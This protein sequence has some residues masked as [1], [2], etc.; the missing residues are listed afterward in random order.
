MSQ[1]LWPARTG[2][3][4]SDG[5]PRSRSTS[6]RR[7]CG[8]AVGHASA[9]A[10]ANVHAFLWRTEISA[11]V[12][13]FTPHFQYPLFCRPVFALFL[14]KKHWMTISHIWSREKV[15]LFDV[16]VF[17]RSSKF[18]R[19]SKYSSGGVAFLATVNYRSSQSWTV[20]VRL[21]F[22]LRVVMFLIT[23]V[24]LLPLTSNHR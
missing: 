11:R 24:K 8:R 3:R 13:L 17:C 20:Y 14:Q 5:A 1:F 12:W 6:T 23:K 15:A 21:F 10:W 9:S 4:T 22:V 2:A 16:A 7:G 18:F 19:A